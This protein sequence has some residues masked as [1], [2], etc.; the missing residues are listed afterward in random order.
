M[1]TLDELIIMCDNKYAETKENVIM[2]ILDEGSV[3][4]IMEELTVNCPVE[5]RET[6]DFEIFVNMTPTEIEEKDDFFPEV[7]VKYQP[8]NRDYIIKIKLK[9]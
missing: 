1:M 9:Y 6:M 3:Y 7:I 8:L 2:I 5:I 4:N